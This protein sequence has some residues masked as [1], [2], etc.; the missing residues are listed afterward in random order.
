M[1]EKLAVHVEQ[2]A[3]EFKIPGR[4]ERVRAVDEAS[5]S[6]ARGSF[7]AIVGASGSGKSTLML[8][9][10]GL[11]QPT[12]GTVQILGK[13]TSAMGRSQRATF[14]AAN[15][16]FIFQD[17]NLVSSLTARENVALPGKLRHRA[18]KREAV[19]EALERVGLTGQARRRPSALSGGERQRV[20]VA[21]VLASQPAVIF[22]DEPTAA[23]DLASGHKV[24]GWLREAADSGSAVLMVTHDAQAAARA[25]R[26]LVMDSGRI[27]SE[28]A[29]GDS[30]A[31]SR[32]VLDERTG[33]DALAASDKSCEG[34]LR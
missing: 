31:V 13:E 20:A 12:S 9:V 7:T 29:G 21:R 30:E 10:A 25:D 3:R 16:G 14:R 1:T 17:G 15:V 19:D 28:L 32:E 22:A 11:D 4:R 2:L 24:L 34:A 27:A 23:L 6:L 18:L 33:H 8:C 5:L 26:V